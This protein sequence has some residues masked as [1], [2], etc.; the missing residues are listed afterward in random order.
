MIQCWAITEFIEA[1]LHCGHQDAARIIV[2]KLEEQAKLTPS[3]LL[4]IGLCYARPVLADVE[5]AE[6]LFQTSLG[7]DINR[8][9]FHRARLLLAYSRWLRRQRRV[10]KSRAPLREAIAAFDAL[11]ALPWGEWARQELRAAG[12]TSRSRSAEARVELT[13]QELQI[14][15]MAAEGMTNKD[16][17]NLLYLSHRTIGSHLYR[18]S[19]KLAI[20]ARYQLREA[21]KSISGSPV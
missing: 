8:W 10:A 7:A 20:T 19:P 1:A 12:E 4:Q 14:A 16:I 5:H 3:P 11:C 9:P 18:I 13:P 15:R 21:L 17:G 2:A 6:L